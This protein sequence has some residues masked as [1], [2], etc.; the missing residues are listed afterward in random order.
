MFVRAHRENL[1][2]HEMSRDGVPVRRA[3]VVGTRRRV[4]HLDPARVREHRRSRSPA[5]SSSSR[6]SGRSARTSSRLTPTT[7]LVLELSR[8][9]RLS[10][11]TTT[12]SG[13][14][15][16]PGFGVVWWAAA[17]RAASSGPRDDP[18]PVGAELGVAQV[19]ADPA[20]EAALLR[21][22]VGH[23]A[24]RRRRP[25]PSRRR[26]RTRRA[27][28][29]SLPMSCSN[30]ARDPHGS[31]AYGVSAS[32]GLHVAGDADRVAAIVVGLP[33]PQGERRR[34]RAPTPTHSTSSAR[35]GPGRTAPEEAAR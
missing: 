14:A 34:D 10:S 8:C 5:G 25:P 11:A 24:A 30:A 26:A 4:L 2:R 7:T 20:G 12:T 22:R 21:P 19:E 18:D 6:S 9:R 23:V 35:G 32:C 28:A 17:Q 13:I 16:S 33:L 3:R 29:S 31:S 1:F 27:A 15:R